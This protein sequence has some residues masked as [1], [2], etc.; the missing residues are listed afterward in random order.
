MNLLSLKGKNKT[1]G[2]DIAL[3]GLYALLFVDSS[4]YLI[5]ST[6]GATRMIINGIAIFCMF[7]FSQKEK[8]FESKKTL[9]YVMFLVYSTL[10]GLLVGNSKQVIILA[11]C[12]T[13]GFFVSI[14]FDKA[15]FASSYN[16]VLYILC[17]FSLCATALFL[18]IPQVVISLPTVETEI[19]D[20][21]F[22]NAIFTIVA[23]NSHVL[24]NYGIFWEPGAFAVFI[25]IAIYHE[26]FEFESISIKRVVI[27]TATLLT[28]LSTLGVVCLAVLYIAYFIDSALNSQ[29][30]NRKV[31]IIL[32][33]LMIAL[34]VVLLLRG[35]DF[36]FH[37]FGKFSETAS[38]EMNNSL[39]V[40]LD[41]FKYPFQSFI[42]S[43]VFGLG[44]SEYLVVQH[45]YCN[46]L[47]TF[48]H[49]NWLMTF[50][51]VGSIVPVVGCARYFLNRKQ[52][53]ASKLI[54]M[55]F[56]ILLF[57]TE[58]FLLISFVYILIFLGF[59]SNEKK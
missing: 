59:N 18:V 10:S 52:A 3:I 34:S 33:V 2:I 47:A 27:Y 6:V 12:I 42:T 29:G 48:T 46:D 16:K 22:Y 7:F 36:I 28:T 55:L 32:F 11:L 39:S 23:D 21:D 56:S 26:F 31:S 30:Q 58:N 17:I 41:S 13:G 53:S 25:S 24:R 35:D 57:S 54:L 20:V 14:V 43:P 51:I 44:I 4:F 38:G 1:T 9:A 49:M 45:D 37:V 50:G 5:H 40:R 15:E 8:V 19:I